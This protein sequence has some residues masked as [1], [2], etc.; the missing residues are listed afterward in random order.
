MDGRVV[1]LCFSL[2]RAFNNP[3]KRH[4]VEDVGGV[5]CIDGVDVTAGI[6]DNGRL[7]GGP[8]CSASAAA[9]GR[10]EKA[11]ATGGVGDNFRDELERSC[12]Q[13]S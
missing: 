4:G 3:P 11:S 7:L 9:M 8:W 12:A 1:G 2:L 10:G 13:K 6:D 5:A